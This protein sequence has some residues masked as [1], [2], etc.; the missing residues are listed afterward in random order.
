MFNIILLGLTSLLTDFSSEMIIPLLPFFI[1]L[2]GGGG[3]ALGFIFGFGDALAAIFKVISGYWADRTRKYKQFVFWGYVFSAIAKFLYPIAQSWQ[4][5]AVIR[6]FERIGKGIRDAPRDAIVSESLSDHE[7]G[8]GFGVQRAMDSAGAIVGSVAVLLLYVFLNVS[9][10]KIFLVA[11]FIG[12]LAVIPVFFVDIPKNL[13]IQKQL[14]GHKLPARLKKFIAAATL[15]ALANFSVAFFILQ[16]QVSFFNLSEKQTLGL[17]LVVY[18]F[19]NLFQA[20]FSEPAGS[21]SDKIGRRLVIKIGY[22]I[23][24]FVSL[25]FLLI[26]LIHPINIVSFFTLLVLFALYGLFN[27]FIDASQ[28]AYVS[29]LSSIEIRGTALGTFD[30]LIGLAAIPAGLIAGFLWNISSVITFGFGF[31]VSLGAIIFLSLVV[32]ED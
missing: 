12:L 32:G 2:L 4:H 23:F 20:A 18:I 17:V 16:A 30:T 13:S 22:G 5:L 26:A 21:L 9:I 28:R 14:N 27:A 7:R 31:V 6:P 25:G 3:I 24:S 19:F 15:F 8:K 10:P 11:A 1:Q 29:D